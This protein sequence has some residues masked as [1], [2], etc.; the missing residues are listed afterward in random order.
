[1]Y[2]F[3]VAV[4]V[5]AFAIDSANLPHGELLGMIA[6]ICVMQIE[7]NLRQVKVVSQQKY[8][9]QAMSKLFCLT[10]ALFPVLI[11][12]IAEITLSRKY[13]LAQEFNSDI[14]VCYM[15]KDGRVIELTKLCGSDFRATT[16]DS[17]IKSLL[18][19]RECS[20]CS[21]SD[22]NLTGTN[23]VGA[24]LS[25]ADL[26]SANLSGANLLGANLIGANI[27][28]AILK[29]TVMPDGTVHK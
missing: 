7:N 11:L 21:L 2:C 15:Q 13:S 28:N 23:L 29:G 17:A 8:H 16:A 18:T 14:P 24:D 3:E 27:T 6:V 5:L 26:S 20:R 10:S 12:L 22:A 19:T 4:V 1:M 25:Y 9:T